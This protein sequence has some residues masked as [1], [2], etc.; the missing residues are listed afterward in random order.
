MGQWT[1]DYYDDVLASKI[2][3]LVAGS[4]KRSKLEKTEPT[5]NYEAF[6]EE[7]DTGDSFTTSLVDIL[8]KELA[9]RRMRG[10]RRL[11]SDRTAKS[12]RM[13]A[14][15]LRVF[16]ERSA[17]RSMMSRRSVNLSDYMAT[18]DELDMEEDDDD[19]ESMLDSAAT[20]IE[21]ARVNSS[22][23]DA[24]HTPSWTNPSV[25]RVPTR[26][27]PTFS[28]VVASGRSEN[29][30]DSL[31]SPPPQRS[32][33]WPLPPVGNPSGTSLHRQLSIRRPI[34]SRTVDFN[35]FTSR[36]RSSIRQNVESGSARPEPE[37]SVDSYL[38]SS[39]RRRS[40]S[41]LEDSPSGP[42]GSGA[43]RRFFP[44]SRARRRE[45]SAPLWW[46]EAPM[47][48]STD[49]PSDIPFPESG[50]SPSFFSLPT[51][52]SSSSPHSNGAETSDERA[53]P[54]PPTPRLRR[55]GVRTPESL[56]SRHASPTIDTSVP[57]YSIRMPPSPRS[58]LR[59]DDGH[60]ESIADRLRSPGFTPVP[61]T[62]NQNERGPSSVVEY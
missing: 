37:D 17:A 29:N 19:F 52:A 18:Q 53:Y 56:L 46:S 62:D 3:G 43:A 21:G 12:L 38:S 26:P 44:F 5:I 2:K 32:G 47:E 36:R 6:V 20:A 22:L 4:I 60:E 34:R 48:P 51:P 57:T 55:G 24:Y 9:E 1:A 25:G 40:H 45:S 31:P 35:D 33:P 39:L 54:P 42:R 49:G 58:P 59:F 27:T 16:R 28:A 8:V 14:T 41:P 7:L 30:A 10:E 11:I 15:P 50:A 23:Y 61:Q 13:L